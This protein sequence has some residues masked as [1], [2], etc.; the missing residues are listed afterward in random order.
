MTRTRLYQASAMV[1]RQRNLGEA[2]RILTLYSRE[3]GKLAAVAKGVRRPRS[4]L[5]GSLQLFTYADVQLAAGRTLD[6][7]T[8][9]HA[10]ESFYHLR[11]DM[12]RYTHA[13]YLAELL[14]VLTEEGLADP[15][16]FDLLLHALTALNEDADPPTVAH[17]F[18][19]RL[20]ARLG[21]G[22]ELDTCTICGAAVGE[23]AG[24]FST[25]QG[26]V[27]CHRCGRGTAI[28]VS[29]QTRRVMHELRDVELEVIC[30]RRLTREVA[31]EIGQLLQRFITF[32]VDRPLRSPAFLTLG[33]TAS[34]PP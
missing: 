32:H 7:V 34:A 5:A 23:V 28:Q 29:S 6:I 11:Q 20:L 14:D 18:E 3:H 33:L 21:Y 26:G 27:L 9:A 19:L 1:I 4:K 24:G 30:A 31:G 12:A 25:S 17:A 16:V 15:E 10:R 13:S 8:Q 22:P 2:D